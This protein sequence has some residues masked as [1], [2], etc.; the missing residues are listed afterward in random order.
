[1]TAAILRRQ[2]NCVL[3]LRV[4]Y[5]AMLCTTPVIGRGVRMGYY[6]NGELSKG[7][8]GGQPSGTAIKFTRST[9][10]VRGLPVRI[11]DADPHTTCQAML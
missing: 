1:M 9:L 11:L 8:N 6:I 3:D 5:R 2:N 10:A 4:M 7:H